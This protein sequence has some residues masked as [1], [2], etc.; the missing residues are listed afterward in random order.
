MNPKEWFVLGIRLFGLWLLTRGMNYISAFA[1][2]KLGLSE[3]PRGQNPTGNILYAAFDFAVAAYFLL[4][5]RHF[6]KLCES[7]E[8]DPE[9]TDD[10]NKLD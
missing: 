7:E 8:P 1:D 2:L 4:G 10:T 5:A 9:P 6:A 3:T